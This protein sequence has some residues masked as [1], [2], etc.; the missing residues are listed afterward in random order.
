MVMD[1]HNIVLFFR[2]VY[3]IYVLDV[4]LF[5]LSMFVSFLS[6]YRPCLRGHLCR[7]IRSHFRWC[8]RDV[9]VHSM[10]ESWSGYIYGDVEFG[11]CQGCQFSC[12]LMRTGQ[13]DNG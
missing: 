6:W 5:C 13:Y 1:L 8:V 9:I 4:V 3:F 10:G 12:F 2:L 11:C 7:L